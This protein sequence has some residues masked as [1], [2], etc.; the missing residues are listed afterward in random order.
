MSVFV[1]GGEVGGAADQLGYSLG[2]PLDH[3]A[4]RLAS[5][6]RLARI[7]ARRVRIE[8]LGHAPLEHVREGLRILR[9]GLAVGGKALRPLALVLGAAL[10]GLP[11]VRQRL[12][13]DE[14][15][16]VRVP[17]VVLLGLA[18]VFLAERR[19]VRLG[20]VLQRAAVA[21]V[22]LD[23]DERG[24]ALLRHRLACHALEPLDREVLTH[25]HDVP[26]IRLE[27]LADVL[28]HGDVHHAGEL[29]AVRVVVGNQAAEPEVPC[30]RAGLRGHA[31]LHVAV[32]RDRER[33]VVDDL[34]L[35][36]IEAR[37]QHALGEGEAD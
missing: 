18:H 10:A 31:L 9:V 6:H 35:T 33:V 27:A 4:G 37:G 30:E 11:E 26:A 19:A 3:R 29:D 24:P 7:E 28:A 15:V 32:A 5:G 21:D 20:R 2:R 23:D 1:D 16:S 25:V 14:E 12:V 36:A 34:V 22:R 8:A 17:A 13:R